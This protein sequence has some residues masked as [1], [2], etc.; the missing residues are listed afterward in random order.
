MNTTGNRAPKISFQNVHKAERK[1]IKDVIDNRGENPFW[2]AE[3]DELAG[4]GIKLKF[5]KTTSPCGGGP[6]VV[7]VVCPEPTNQMTPGPNWEFE[8]NQTVTIEFNPI[9]ILNN[10]KITGVDVTEHMAETVIHEILHVVHGHDGVHQGYEIG[11]PEYHTQVVPRDAAIY[12]EDIY[13]GDPSPMQTWHDNGNQ[14]PSSNTVHNRLQGIKNQHPQY[15][16]SLESGRSATK[17]HPTYDTEF[18]IG[19]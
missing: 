6:D 14:A 15:F 17:Q 5:K 1:I 16:D 9:G 3:L 11:D 4:R 10:S 7:A 12:Y 2:Q 8:D 19:F 13:D 18:I